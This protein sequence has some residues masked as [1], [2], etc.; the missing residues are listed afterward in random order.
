MEVITEFPKKTYG[1][2]KCFGYIG[3]EPLF[4]IG[5]DCNK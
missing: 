3:E 4:C 1:K 5:P 2:L